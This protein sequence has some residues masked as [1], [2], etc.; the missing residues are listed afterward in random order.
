MTIALPWLMFGGIAVMLGG[1]SLLNAARNRKRR[2]AYAEYSLVRGFTFE[3][4]RPNGERRYADAFEPFSAGHRRTW[5]YT[6]SGTKNQAAFTAFEYRWVTGSG[7]SSSAHRIGGIVWERDTD[8]LPKFALSPENWLSRVGQVF[9]MQDIDFDES[10][11]FSKMYRLKGP[12]EPLIRKLFTSEIRRFFEA[13]PKQQVAGG[14]RFLFWFRH[15]PMPPVDEFDEWLEQGD[16]VR[17]RF[18]QP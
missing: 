14:G 18:F 5:G 17:R 2:E 11:E 9:G 6:I 1:M 13:T 3:E 10:P 16:H 4:K 12:N 8:A 7:K 15:G